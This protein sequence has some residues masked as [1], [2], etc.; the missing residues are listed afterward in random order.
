[1]GNIVAKRRFFRPTTTAASSWTPLWRA[2]C[3]AGLADRDATVSGPTPGE[4][5]NRNTPMTYDAPVPGREGA[6]RNLWEASAQ[7]YDAWIAEAFGDQYA[8]NWTT[9]ARHMSPS[10]RVLD[11][12]CGPG[13]LSLRLARRCQAV[14]GVDVT[15]EMIAVAEQKLAAEPANA[16]FQQA[17]ACDLPFDDHTFDAVVSVNALQ[18]MDQPDKA[19]G[20]MRRVLRPGGELL[21]IAYCYGD[22]SLSEN[23]SLLDWAV[24][25]GGKTIWHSFTFDQLV[26]LLEI[27]E[28]DVVEARRI[29]EK[30]VVAFLRGKAAP[31]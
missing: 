11:V 17:D 18:A 1:M 14:W 13:T 22:S 6:D 9:L 12:G 19:L 24:K 31:A 26:G 5:D 28:F 20:E 15:P 16:C 4:N 27:R 8:V 3:P 30:P 10:L 25:Y 29:W 21:L 2:P 7:S 23:N